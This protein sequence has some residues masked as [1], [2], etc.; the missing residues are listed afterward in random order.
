[1]I[2]LQT[3]RLVLSQMAPDDAE[4]I[5]R[6]LNDEAFIR[7]IG[8]KGVR[9][10]ADA[11]DYLRNGPMYSY[12]KNG[13]GLYLVRRLADNTRLGMCGLVRREGLDGPDLGFA[14]LPE[15]RCHGYAYESAAAVLAHARGNLGLGRILG[16]TS[17]DNCGSIRLLEKAGFAFERRMRLSADDSEVNLYASEQ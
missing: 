7:F 13:F 15:F 17:P 16:I 6:L 9:S 11:H 3:E 10:I 1:M 4:F 14:F 2:V 5:L 12:R 8:D